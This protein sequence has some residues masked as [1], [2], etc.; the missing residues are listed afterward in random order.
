MTYL[1]TS[2]TTNNRSQPQS[3]DW[4]RLLALISAAVKSR[5]TLVQI[6]EKNL[7]TSSLYRL[8]AEA[9][10]VT[11]GT[12]TR[13]LVNDRADV[14]RACGA[15]GVHL[16]TR[17]LEATVVRRAFGDDFLIGVSAHTLAE[18]TAAR[19]GGANFA[20]F[21]PIFATPSKLSDGAPAR[22]MEL[23][24]A[25]RALAPFPLV[26]LG[27]VTTENAAQAIEAGARGVAAIRMF[28]DA[29]QLPE[30]LRLLR[31]ALSLKNE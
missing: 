21:S 23:S 22:L 16:T 5:I 9:L 17:S 4:Q 26:A 11:R 3:E 7:P 2:G 18:A 10:A 15:D 29:E 1:I 19:D 25:A 20:T 28:A 12:E 6:R 24:E 14:A 30:T 31:R 8:T 27:G 13:L